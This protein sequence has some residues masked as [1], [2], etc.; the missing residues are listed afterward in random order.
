[1]NIII[2]KGTEADFESVFSLVME[3]A[4][5]QGVPERVENSVSQMKNEQGFFQCLVAETDEEEIVGMASYFFAYYTWVG[6]SLYLDDLIVKESHRGKKIGTML[7]E[8]IFEIAKLENCKRVRWLVSA[9]NE[10]AIRFYKSIGAEMDMEAW[11]C[12]VQGAAISSL[13]MKLHS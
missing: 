11:V 2:R 12:D 7:L 8:A 4:E 5:F 3:L 9:W 10:Q 13:R 1:M 6:K